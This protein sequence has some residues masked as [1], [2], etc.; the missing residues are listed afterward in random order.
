MNNLSSEKTNCNPVLLKKKI[1]FLSSRNIN[2]SSNQKNINFSRLYTVCEES[3]CPNQRECSSHGSAAFLIGGNICTRNCLFCGVRSGK[4]VLHNGKEEKN[5]LFKAV[6][7]LQLKHV[8]ITSVTRDDN[9]SFLADHYSEIIIDLKKKNKTVEVLI[10]D[11]H[12][13]PK[14]L[15]K[16]LFASPHI[17]AHNI[18]TTHSLSKQIRPQADYQRSID[19]LK[20]FSQKKESNFYVKSGMM[21]GLGEKLDDI[22]QEIRVL[23]KIGVDILTIGQYFPPYKHSYP[24]Q[25]L[26]SQKE[27]N[28]IRDYSKRFHFEA[29]EVSPFA[30]SS[31][32]AANTLKKIQD[33]N[34]ENKLSGI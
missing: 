20:W 10:P 4:P 24:M 32:M 29:I 12:G 3:R 18:E 31:Y 21:I 6:D 1:P 11:F 34:Y 27:F 7:Q 14:Y 23:N 28:L 13:N 16:I 26:Y 22:F 8:V 9:E 25:K 5:A 19:L 17:L 2:S 33:Q 30:R 15:Q